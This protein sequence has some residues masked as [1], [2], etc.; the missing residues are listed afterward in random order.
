M[1]HSWSAEPRLTPEALEFVRF[2]YRRRRVGWPE[3]YDEMCLV[4]GRRLYREMGQAELAE[5]G[6]GFALF[7]MPALLTLVARV[8]E[9]E[10]PERAARSR[11]PLPRARIGSP[12]EPHSEPELAPST[13]LSPASAA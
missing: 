12:A 10:D 4:A 9:E 1:E 2:C 8:I 3:L 5:H 11:R 7:E 6:V 13:E